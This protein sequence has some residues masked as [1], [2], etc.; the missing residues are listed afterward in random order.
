MPELDLS[1]VIPAYNE[2]KR[3][4]KTLREI[5]HFLSHQNLQYEII[6]S[7]DGSS[8]KTVEAARHCLQDVEHKIIET[9]PNRGKGHA[10]RAGMLAGRGNYILFS[11]ADLSTPIEEL[12]AFL[13]LLKKDQDIVIGSRALDRSKIEVRQEFFREWMGKVFNRLARFLTFKGIEDSQC[14]FK[15]FRR[16]AAHK[17]FAMQKLDGFS[18][19]VEVIYLAQKCGYK[20]FEKSVVWRHSPQTRVRLLLD[21]MLMF[22]DILKIRLMHL[23]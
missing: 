2:E 11:D 9:K 5:I 10:V 1:V 22:L 17:L 19:D 21:P 7:D 3:I 15:C 8:D 13:E 14:G 16:E 18:F 12:P 4:E 20:V 23:R 6:V